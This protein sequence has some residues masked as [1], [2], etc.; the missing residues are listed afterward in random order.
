M[1]SDRV[2]VRATQ[3]HDPTQEW[4]TFPSAHPLPI[5]NPLATP[6]PPPRPPPDM[7]ICSL[8]GRAAQPSQ[9]GCPQTTELT[10]APSS[11]T[12]FPVS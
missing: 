2:F 3:P 4:P 6:R 12:R 10:A 9:A 5:L 11:A 1:A 7:H 8:P